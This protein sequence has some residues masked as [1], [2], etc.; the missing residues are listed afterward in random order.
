MM[1]KDRH[2]IIVPPMPDNLYIIDPS[3]Q[4]FLIGTWNRWYMAYLYSGLFLLPVTAFLI[5]KYLIDNPIKDNRVNWIIKVFLIVVP[6]LFLLYFVLQKWLS[7][8]KLE[9][10]KPNGQILIGTIIGT[11]ASKRRSGRNRTHEKIVSRRLRYE[12]KSPSGSEL[13]DYTTYWRYNP[14]EDSNLAGR[15][16]AILYA[17]DDEFIAL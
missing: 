14:F 9:R 3:N 13:A 6:I 1:V 12:F 4:P 10:V 17:S 7:W 5:I 11:K 2:Q 16:I 15:P 8:R